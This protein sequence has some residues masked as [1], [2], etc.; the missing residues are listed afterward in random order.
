MSKPMPMGKRLKDDEMKMRK[1]RKLTFKGMEYDL[2]TMSTLELAELNDALRLDARSLRRPDREKSHEE[3]R[4]RMYLSRLRHT[5]A[6][7]VRRES[8]VKESDQ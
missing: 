6:K 5:Q 4:S 8:R 2:K 1:E 7:V 3:N